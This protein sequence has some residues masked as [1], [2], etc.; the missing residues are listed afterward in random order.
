MGHWLLMIHDHYIAILSFYQ[1]KN[2]INVQ[3]IIHQKYR[4][5]H[6]S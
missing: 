3:P 4:T 1:C 2:L 5:N 6:N